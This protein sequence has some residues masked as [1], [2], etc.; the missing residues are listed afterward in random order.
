MKG[1]LGQTSKYTYKKSSP[2][3]SVF[4]TEREN[5]RAKIKNSA[6]K[7]N[8]TSEGLDKPADSLD[9]CVLFG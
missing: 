1:P 9:N 7:R 4:A 5:R 2:V 8:F 3:Y 6:K